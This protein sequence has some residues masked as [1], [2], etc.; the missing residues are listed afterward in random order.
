MQMTKLPPHDLIDLIE[1]E[2]G[3][4]GYD[5]SNFNFDMI[6]GDDELTFKNCQVSEGRIKGEALT[7]SSWTECRFINCD[8]AGTTLREANFTKCDF[9]NSKDV[10]GATFRNSNISR[11]KFTE[12]NLSLTTFSNCDAYDAEFKDCLMRGAIF[13]KTDFSL[14]LGRRHFNQVKFER[15]RMV[16]AILEGLNLSSCEFIACELNGATLSSSRLVN[17]V[18]KKCDLMFTDIRDA[19]F[20][21]ADLRESNLD[22]FSLTDIRGYASMRVSASQQYILLN[23]LGIEIEPD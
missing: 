13:E 19:D 9:Y 17:T 11:A 5:L 15:C 12:C 1:A 4:E 16:D 2:G 10:K 3:C 22:G 21:G 7:V 23:S 18:M 6:D 14:K 8:F 20:S